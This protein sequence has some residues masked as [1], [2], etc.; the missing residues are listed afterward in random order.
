MLQNKSLST[1]EVA[2][3]L[4]VSKSTIYNLI[5]NSEIVSYKVGRK[6][7]F[8]QEDVDDYISRSRHEHNIRPVSTVETDSSFSDF[9]A[10]ERSALVISGQDAILDILAS[11]LNQ[12]GIN[13]SRCY[14][15]GF[16]GLLA[17]YQGKVDIASCHLYAGD[18]EEYN[19]PY[20][21]TIAPG[22]PAMLVNL[23]YRKQG[24]YVKKGNPKKVKGW[25]DLKRD[26]IS[27]V[28]RRLG[29]SSRILLDKKI[30]SLGINSNDIKG[31]DK[32]MGSHLTMASAIASGE[33]DIGL[34]TERVSKQLDGLSFIPLIN[35]RYDLAIRKNQFN[36]SNISGLIKLL[37]SEYFYR[38]VSSI[39]GN[40]YSDIGEIVAEV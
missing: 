12:R 16:E 38:A 15:S 8:T 13:A 1:Q 4:H 18:N 37:R 19:L 10:D 40:D 23:S 7:R 20:L 26:D 25:E 2:D 11:C 30:C 36:T 17:F 9:K 21:K 27:I 22:V 29:S 6:V 31:Y 24:F 32:I 28:N 3:I 14:L 34:G 35:E 33:A 5:K 39:S